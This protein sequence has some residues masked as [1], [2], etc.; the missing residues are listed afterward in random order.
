MSR[1]YVAFLSGLAHITLPNGTDEAYVVGG[2]YGLILAADTANVSTG[3]HITRYPSGEATITLEMPTKG[4]AV[5]LH[6][7][8]H[9][10]A[11]T[12]ADQSL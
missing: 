2:K 3:G 6:R 7:V 10:G 11:C 4:G 12:G 9:A 8:L 5:P 1:R